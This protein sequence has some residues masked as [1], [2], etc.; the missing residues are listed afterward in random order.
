MIHSLMRSFAISLTAF[1][2]MAL[3]PVSFTATAHAGCD[4]SAGPGVVWEKCRKR[5]IIMDGTD[6]SEANLSNSDFTSSDL[7]G[8]TFDNANLEKV[9]LLRASL[10]GSSAKN[11]NFEGALAPRVDFSDSDLENANFEKSEVYRSDFS[12]S[13]LTNGNFS[14]A[15]MA[16]VDF[17]VDNLSGS[18]FQFT[19]LARADLSEADLGTGIDLE[20]S[21]LYLT[22]ITG[23]DL[24]NSTGLQQWQ[25]DLSC[26]DGDTKLPEGVSVPTKWPC[27]E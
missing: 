19:N 20:G 25:I 13:N 27:S 7:R 23:L 2:G 21:Y 9:T 15:E 26:G 3:A 11:A 18:S 22:D 14:K 1:S 24:T 12:N 8:S 5:N 6:F 17:A 4:D 16:R 10:S